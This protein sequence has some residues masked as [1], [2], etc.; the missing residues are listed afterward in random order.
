MQTSA[1]PTSTPRGERSI[2]SG[3][4]PTKTCSRCGASK[5]LSAFHRNTA[6]SDGLQ[7]RCKDCHNE[8]RRTG[9]SVGRP[10]KADRL[11]DSVRDF[12]ALPDCALLGAGAVARLIDVEPCTLTRMAREGRLPAP[13]VE[14]NRRVWTVAA[15]R[16]HLR[17][18]EGGAR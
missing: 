11:P 16:A 14:G 8:A 4:S 7:S 15:M 10:R 17:A 6:T 3:T 5:P 2:Q 9:G 18:G 13:R 12:D 1:A